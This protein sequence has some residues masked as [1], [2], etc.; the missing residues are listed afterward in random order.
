MSAQFLNCSNSVGQSSKQKGIQ[1]EYKL[2]NKIPF[3]EKGTFVVVEQGSKTHFRHNRHLPN[4]SIQDKFVTLDKAN[5][6]I[7]FIDYRKE[8][9]R[10]VDQRSYKLQG[11][12]FKIRQ[13]GG[14]KN[15]YAE[16]MYYLDEN[17][18]IA[19]NSNGNPGFYDRGL[20]FDQ[21]IIKALVKDASGFFPIHIKEIRAQLNSIK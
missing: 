6:S 18:P 21:L 10:L 1:K 9:F 17:G 3:S 5:D 7:L 12:T 14:D 8:V 15:S 16:E 13:Y 2:V 11:K 19:I 4:D 20:P